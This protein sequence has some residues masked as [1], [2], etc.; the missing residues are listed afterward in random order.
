MIKKNE[1]RLNIIKIDFS[2]AE[3]EKLK[4][5]IKTQFKSLL[6]I[7]TIKKDQEKIFGIKI[8][9]NIRKKFIF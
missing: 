3:K 4:S 7:E 1:I 9:K 8:I 5:E 6:N 2:N